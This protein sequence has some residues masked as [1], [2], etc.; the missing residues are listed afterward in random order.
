MPDEHLNDWIDNFLGKVSAHEKIAFIDFIILDN[1]E[2]NMI[3]EK[4][5]TL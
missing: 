1:I 3:E 2:K 4:I 5:R